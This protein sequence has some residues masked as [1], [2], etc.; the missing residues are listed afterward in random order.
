MAKRQWTDDVNASGAHP[1][2]EPPD[3]RMALSLG[4]GRGGGLMARSGPI[5]V[6][7][8]SMGRDWCASPGCGKPREDP[9]H[10]PAES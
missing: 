8:A 3:N 7:M 10:W 6:A 5:T 1:F 2:L 4:G 9:I